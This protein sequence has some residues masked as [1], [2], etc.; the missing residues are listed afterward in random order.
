MD[1]NN[2]DF[3]AN[4]TG[5][6]NIAMVAGNYTVTPVFENPTYFTASPSSIPV[7]F[8]SQTTPQLQNFCIIPVGNH[9][10]LEVSVIPV[11]VARPGFD[12]KYKIIY[13]NK[14]NQ[15]QSGTVNL[16]YDD[17]LM[18]LVSATP[19]ASTQ[20]A[21]DLYW[22][23]SNL[24]PM[25]TREIVVTLN[26]N[27]PTD[28][29]PVTAANLLSYTSGITSALTDE[30]P[31]DNTF[32]L[33]QQVV[34]SYDPN[35]KTC[36]EGA[37]IA[38]TKVGDYV[39]YLIRFENTGSYLAE[40]ITVKDVIDTAKFDIATLEPTN[41]SHLFIT[42]IL[43]GNKVEFFFENIN[44]PFED[45]TNDGYV[46]FK[47]KTKSTLVLGDTFSNS[48]AIYFDYNYP[49]LTNTAVTVVQNPLGTADFSFENYF[50]VYPNPVNDILNIDKK[51]DVEMKAISIYNTLGQLV[52]AI[53]NAYGIQHID[54]SPLK[55]GN[56]IIKIKSDKG[57]LNTKFLKK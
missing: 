57:T 20:V 12:A 27:S 4:T 24:N 55:I 23:F 11:N 50:V 37:S 32:I 40:N 53:P 5:N 16:A 21:N 47:I 39:H 36:L 42:K 26:L 8:P 48:A 30:M 46:A 19:A 25:E 22:N 31:S 44:L 6:Y 2:Y 35:D 54:V 45:S 10:D 3:I 56:Y 1:L 7:T 38:T 15:I 28:T 13:K 52:L 43:N 9:P 17:S 34:N 14:G 29:P 41:G 18:D 51:A 33:N 49:I